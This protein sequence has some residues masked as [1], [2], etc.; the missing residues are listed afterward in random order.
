MNG[1]RPTREVQMC[2][3]SAAMQTS[4]EVAVWEAVA[5]F[6]VFGRVDRRYIFGVKS[7]VKVLKDN[8]TCL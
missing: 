4:G 5:V 8:P 6:G 3:A 1:T 2:S 7:N